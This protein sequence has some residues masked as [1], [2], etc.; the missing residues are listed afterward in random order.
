MSLL[1]ALKTASSYFLCRL[2][3]FSIAFALL[4]CI[5][6]DVCSLVSYLK[7]AFQIE[8]LSCQKV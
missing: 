3:R 2:F 5:K 4:Y 8:C 7:S 6:T 1:P